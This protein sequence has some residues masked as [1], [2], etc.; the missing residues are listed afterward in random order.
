MKAL[1]IKDLK[2]TYSNG[3]EAVKGINLSVEK[4]DFFGLLGPNGAGKTTTI[5][6]ITDLVKKTSGKISILG[7]DFD[8]DKENAKR[9]VGIVPQEFNL[10]I[11][12]T[13][14]NILVYQ[15]G[16]YG[17]R[18]EVALK[19]AE[20]YLKKMDLWDK[21]NQKA[22]QISGGMKRKLMVIRAVM[23][24]PKLV[25]FDEP[26]A[27]LDVEARRAMWKF[28]SDLNKEGKTVILTTHYL[29]EAEQLCKNIAIIHKGNIL[30]NTTVKE[31]IS[32]MHEETFVLDLKDSITKSKLPK[33]FNLKFIDSHTIEA[34]IPRKDNIN[35]LINTLTKKK[36][37]VLSMRN[38][39]NRLEELFVRMTK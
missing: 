1:I 38:K 23:H 25:I 36:I 27:G 11:F 19:R 20:K 5:E 24:D 9:M 6:I 22:M 18:R 2:K 12:D 26:T 34:T 14:I 16:F 4:G 35:D 39:T 21:R 31:L 30:K 7:Y 15:A 28:M 10:S 17:V 33:K 13:I 3:F 32:E 8:E 37:N 29:E